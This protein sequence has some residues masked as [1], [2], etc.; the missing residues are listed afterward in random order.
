MARD[1]TES[2][3]RDS[4]V[5][6][7]RDSTVAAPKGSMKKRHFCTTCRAPGGFHAYDCPHG[8]QNT[9]KHESV[10]TDSV[11]NSPLVAD[12]QV[13]EV[14][15]ECHHDSWSGWHCFTCDT[16]VAGK[17]VEDDDDASTSAESE[18]Q[19]VLTEGC[20]SEGGNS[21]DDAMD[22]C[23]TSDGKVIDEDG[24]SEGMPLAFDVQSIVDKYNQMVDETWRVPLPLPTK[25]EEP[26][27]YAVPPPV[28]ASGVKGAVQRRRKDQSL[29][30]DQ[31]TR[32][33]PPC[34]C[35]C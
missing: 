6:V 29:R 13:A 19:V 2:V 34:P 26:Q 3:A 22:E 18:Q 23:G 9:Q 21:E 5:A 33:A 30:K 32:F 17:H 8:M 24:N 28:V 12:E 25:V 7:P 14:E 16:T 4:T 1:S 27:K 20:V 15:M 35:G 31:R 10:A 11:V